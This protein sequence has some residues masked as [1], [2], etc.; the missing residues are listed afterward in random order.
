MSMIINSLTID[1]DGH[2]T[3]QENEILWLNVSP[4]VQYSDYTPPPP[5]PCSLKPH[6][7]H[8][9]L[10]TQITKLMILIGF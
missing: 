3:V 2:T 9:S 5:P 6:S 7:S 8:A 10:G 4:V 1:F